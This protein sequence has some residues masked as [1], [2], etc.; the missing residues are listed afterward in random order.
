MTCSAA[1]AASLAAAAILA[2][3]ACDARAP[4]ASSPATSGNVPTAESR[5]FTRPPFVPSTFVA[6]I[7]NPYLPSPQARSSAIAAGPPTGSRSTW[8]GSLGI[9]SPSS[10]SAP[11]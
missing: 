2:L 1:T 7:T 9:P 10:A 6:V 3:Q 11:P 5:G 4:T 8:C